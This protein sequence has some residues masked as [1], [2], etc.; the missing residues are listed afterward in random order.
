MIY[1]GPES[2]RKLLPVGPPP[3]QTTPGVA[4]T[5]SSE[6]HQRIVTASRGLEC[7]QLTTKYAIMVS[8]LY[9]SSAARH[10]L[11]SVASLECKPGRASNQ[12]HAC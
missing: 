9:C 1:T 2:P 4:A 10:A 6:H 8:W 11:C 12:P 3:E 5:V 7:T